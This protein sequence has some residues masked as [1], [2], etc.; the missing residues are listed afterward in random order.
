M[1]TGSGQIPCRKRKVRCDLGPVD[2]P[3][4]P[5]CQRC[6]R[7]SKECYFSATRRKRPWEDDEEGPGEHEPPENTAAAYN[8]RKRSARGS[9]V[10]QYANHPSMGDPLNSGASSA[11]FGSDF[12]S[13]SGAHLPQGTSRYDYPH[14]NGKAEDG[15][16]QEVTNATA[17]ALFQSPINSPGDALHLLLQASGQSEGIQQLSAAQHG[18]SGSR[19]PKATQTFTPSGFAS[20]KASRT[21]K[22]RASNE[23]TAIDPAIARLGA[24]QGPLTTDAEILGIWSRL[25]FVRAG[26]FSAKEA[27]ALID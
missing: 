24:P 10:H 11:G 25:R 1:L 22:S 18:Q 19:A 16:D 21:Q 2:D 6:R 20:A 14:L 17:A 23:E 3:H 8:V 4:D 15:L 9:D 7:E 13:P 26:W 5:P 27:I 12:R